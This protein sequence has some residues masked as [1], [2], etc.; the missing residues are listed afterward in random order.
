MNGNN[1]IFIVVFPAQEHLELEAA[2]V[3][4]LGLEIIGGFGQ[5]GLIG[6]FLGQ[7]QENFQILEASFLVLPGLQGIG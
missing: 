5:G 2:E 1:G 7:V 4:F 3:F 6:F